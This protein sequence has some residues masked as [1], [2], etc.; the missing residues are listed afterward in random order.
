L[1]CVQ[2]ENIDIVKAVIDDRMTS[3]GACIEKSQK[4][5]IIRFIGRFVFDISQVDHSR[6]YTGFEQLQQVRR[7]TLNVL[8]DQFQKIFRKRN[9][10][11]K[12]R[13]QR[14]FFGRR[15]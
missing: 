1:H 3:E 6:C 2:I 15:R 8:V 14:V 9:V 11:K 12:K 7:R 5:C 10:I 4:P 13:D